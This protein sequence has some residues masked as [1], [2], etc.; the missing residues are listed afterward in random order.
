MKIT[1]LPKHGS[2]EEDKLSER[3]H[4]LAVDYERISI[5]TGRM[6]HRALALHRNNAPPTTGNHNLFSCA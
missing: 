4:M 5:R 3:D 2:A 1:A 6:I